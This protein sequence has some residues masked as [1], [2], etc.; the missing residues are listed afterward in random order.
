MSADGQHFMAIHTVGRTDFL[1]AD[2]VGIVVNSQNA[3]FAAAGTL[4]SWV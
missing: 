3:T 4:L 1:T 2:E